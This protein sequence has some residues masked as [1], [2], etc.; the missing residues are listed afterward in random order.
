MALG[1]GGLP[2]GR[3]IEIYG[4]EGAGKTT[5]VA[6]ILAAGQDDGERTAFIDVEHRIDPLY[7]EKLGLLP[8]DDFVLIQPADGEDGFNIVQRLLD[9]GVKRVAIDSMA[10]L[11]TKEEI[12]AANKKGWGAMPQP[13]VQARMLSHVIKIMTPV[14]ARERAIILFTNQ[15][16]STMSFLGS[17]ETTSGGKAPKFYESVRLR[18]SRNAG[19]EAI[20]NG[21]WAKLVVRKNNYGPP[22]IWECRLIYGKGFDIEYDVFQTAVDH[23]IITRR[24]NYYLFRG[25]ELAVGF[26][27]SMEK[28]RDDPETRGLILQAIRDLKGSSLSEPPAEEE[29]KDETGDAPDS[30]RGTVDGSVEPSDHPSPTE[31]N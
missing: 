31:E 17:S 14:V 18:L 16:R 8:K 11:L 2:A 29:V 24:G 6:Q 10:A 5:L 23:G 19:K 4:P 21:F 9:A 1:I 27:K 3:F 25:M 28:L 30:D 13:G 7:L 12:A 22:A 26:D 20:G 15:I